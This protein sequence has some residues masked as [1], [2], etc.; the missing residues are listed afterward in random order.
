MRYEVTDDDTAMRLGSGDVPVLAT[1]RL[2]AWL[3]AAT[4]RAAVPFLGTGQTSVGTAVRVEHLRATRVGGEIEVTAE[5][6]AA[7]AG[8]RLTF[9][10][11]A[12]DGSGQVVATGEI[13]RAVVDRQRFL[14]PPP[15]PGAGR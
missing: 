4:V 10:V 15:G 14:T 7:P 3:E 13:E 6:P 12:V 8:R 5:P 11:R 9:T 1:P 2:I